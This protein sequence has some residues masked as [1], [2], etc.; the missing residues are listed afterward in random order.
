[1]ETQM[2]ISKLRNC[3]QISKHIMYMMLVLLEG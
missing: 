2:K 1:M 3:W